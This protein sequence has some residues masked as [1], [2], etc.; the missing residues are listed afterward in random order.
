MQPRYSPAG[1]KNDTR[2]LVEGPT[3]GDAKFYGHWLLNAAKAQALLEQAKTDD[4]RFRTAI[5]T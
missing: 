5:D 3:W 2:V 4:P 1:E